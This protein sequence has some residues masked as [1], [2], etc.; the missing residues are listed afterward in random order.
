MVRVIS[1]LSPLTS[2]RSKPPQVKSKLYEQLRKSLLA[3]RFEQRVR[4]STHGWGSRCS[5]SWCSPYGR[6]ESYAEAP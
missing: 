1:P 2:N 5:S 4:S 6:A 3:M